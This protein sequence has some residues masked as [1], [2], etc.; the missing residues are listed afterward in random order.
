MAKYEGLSGTVQTAIRNPD[1]MKAFIIGFPNCGKTCLALDNEHGYHINMDMSSTTHPNPKCPSWPEMDPNTSMPLENGKPITMSWDHVEKQISSLLALAKSGK[2]RPKTIYLDS[3]SSMC[4]LI[5]AWIPPNAANIKI[6]KSG[7]TDWNEVHGPSA[8]D[9]MYDRIVRVIESLSNAGYGVVLFG[10]VCRENVTLEEDDGGSRI[11]QRTNLTITSGFW[12][13]LY[14]LF[15]F[16]AYMYSQKETKTVTVTQTIKGRSH[17]KNIGKPVKS[18]YLT[19]HP[20]Q[21]YE[22]E[23]ILKR[24]VQFPQKLAIPQVGGWTTFRD[25]YLNS[26]LEEGSD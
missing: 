25:A 26:P 2:P 20:G 15:E 13:R 3:L 12:K 8:Y 6:A 21:T 10:H 23:G 11:I 24:R 19:P 14:D 5:K 18:F 17:N 22:L 9:W 7:L 4:R 1:S 16:V